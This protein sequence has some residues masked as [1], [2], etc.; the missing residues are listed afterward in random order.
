MGGQNFTLA[1]EQYVVPPNAYAALN[2]TDD[3]RHYTWFA[4]AGFQADA[5]LGQAW[6]QYFY[7]IYD[8]G[9]ESECAGWPFNLCCA[10]RGG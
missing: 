10:R 9:N 8:V 7:S 4:S 5:I 3:G 6:L 1:P 2:L